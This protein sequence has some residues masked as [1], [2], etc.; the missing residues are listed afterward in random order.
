VIYV[1]KIEKPEVIKRLNK[2]EEKNHK[3]K[4]KIEMKLEKTSTEQNKSRS[5]PEKE[6]TIYSFH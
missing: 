5:P 3:T 2:D 1:S 4:I 6:I